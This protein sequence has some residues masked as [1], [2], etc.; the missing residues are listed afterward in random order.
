MAKYRRS[1][2]YFVFGDSFFGYIYSF[3]VIETKIGPCYVSLF[4]PRTNRI[5]RD[6]FRT[7][8]YRYSLGPIRLVFSSVNV[9]RVRLNQRSSGFIAGFHTYFLVGHHNSRWLKNRRSRF[10]FGTV[11][12]SAIFI[13]VRLYVSCSFRKQPANTNLNTTPFITMLIEKRF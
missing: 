4:R 1:L 13:N 3:G 2:S 11:G 5:D 10:L 12:I 8:F 7:Y 6:F 9:G